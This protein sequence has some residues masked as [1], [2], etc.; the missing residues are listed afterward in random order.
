M[1]AL[2]LYIIRHAEKPDGK[3]PSETGPGLTRKGKENEAALVIT[4]WQRA[5]AWTA[6]FGTG[7]GG[8]D[9]LRPQAIFAANPDLTKND[10]KVS[11]RPYETVQSLAAR[12]GLGKPDSSF[13]KGQEKQ[14]VD[15][16][17]T[18]S[19]VVLVSWEHK[20]IVNEILPR[21]PVSNK[22]DLPSHWSGKRFDVVLRLD[23]AAGASQFAFKEMHPLLMP[24]D[25]DRPL[26]S[27]PKDD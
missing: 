14:L 25:S 15:A 12:I 19:G 2:T 26:N 16:L 17:L 8:V 3:N 11:R 1:N 20:G 23:R 22:G 27:D 24:G 13:A 6:L 9:Y 7:L 5:G 4:G 10:S 21:L 18:R